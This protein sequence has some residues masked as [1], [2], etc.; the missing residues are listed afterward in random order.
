MAGRRTISLVAPPMHAFAAK[1][2][3]DDSPIAG[4]VLDVVVT[5]QPAVQSILETV[6]EN[7]VLRVQP[8]GQKEW[9]AQDGHPEE[10]SD[11]WGYVKRLHSSLE[12]IKYRVNHGIGREDC[13]RFRGH[14]C[15]TEIGPYQADL[16]GT[17]LSMH[18]HD[19]SSACRENSCS[20]ERSPLVLSFPYTH[21]STPRVTH[22]SQEVPMHNAFN[23]SRL[24][25]FRVE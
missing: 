25:A 17:S 9:R 5:G 4:R 2:E 20:E 22:E 16:A 23:I 3:S 10:H 12:L 21:S 8:R 15:S 13:Q 7:R 18:A 19:R 6:G 24:I 14:Q 1:G 11:T